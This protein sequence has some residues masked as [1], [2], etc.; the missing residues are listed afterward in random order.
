MDLDALLTESLLVGASEALDRI[1]DELVALHD[2]W[3][4]A[5]ADPES[6]IWLR[7]LISDAGWW[8]GRLSAGLP[9]RHT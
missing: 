8:S 3:L 1:A 7:G 2:V 5:N 9:L 6:M 4:K